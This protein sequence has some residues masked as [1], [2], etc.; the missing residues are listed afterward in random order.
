MASTWLAHLLVE[1]LPGFRYC[2]PEGLARN[3]RNQGYDMTQKI[4]K[5]LRWKLTVVR[6]HTP[7]TPANIEMRNRAFGRYVVQIRDI[8]DVIVSVYHHIKKYP[9]SAFVDPGH[10][11]TL[12]WQ[13]VSWDVLG[14]N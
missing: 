5:E 6:S 9:Q 3:E 8:R 7:A 10:H 2:K 12:P 11:R 1:L 13:P 14:L 4:V